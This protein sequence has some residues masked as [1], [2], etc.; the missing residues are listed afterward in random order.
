M[1][2]TSDARERILSSAMEL[3]HAQSYSEVGVNE[4]CEHAGVKKGS[5]Y[6]F[7]PSK[8]DLVLAALDEYDLRYGPPAVG[9]TVAADEPPLERIRAVLTRN[10]EGMRQATESGR[11]IR[12]CFVG[13]MALELSTQDA[14]VRARLEQILADW[15]AFFERAIRDAVT[16]GDLPETVD[17]RRNAKA[18]V[19]YIEGMAMMAKTYNDPT[20]A[21]Q[22]AQG[23]MALASAPSIGNSEETRDEE[24]AWA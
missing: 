6:H 5:F 22:L 3:F 24:A 23:T 19:A 7:F 10:A 1:G 11:A 14:V 18:V 20:W 8:R 13:N 2:R 9:E 21:A 15:L 17:P 4:L 12:G 16:V